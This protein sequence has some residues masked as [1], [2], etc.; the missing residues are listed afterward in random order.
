ML[1]SSE[2]PD[3]NITA[4]CINKACLSSNKAFNC[5]QGF[6]QPFYRVEHAVLLKDQDK[7]QSTCCKVGHDRLEEETYK[8]LIKPTF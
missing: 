4:F 8:P 1:D 6:M 3:Y 7:S 2:S 5:K